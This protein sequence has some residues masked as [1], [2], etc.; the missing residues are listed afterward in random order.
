VDTRSVLGHTIVKKSIEQNVPEV[1]H[2]GTPKEHEEGGKS[3][4]KFEERKLHDA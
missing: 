4:I 1:E 3:S 2:Y